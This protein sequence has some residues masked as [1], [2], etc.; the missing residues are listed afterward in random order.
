VIPEPLFVRISVMKA[1][2]RID[3]DALSRRLLGEKPGL[4]AQLKMVPLPPPTTKTYAD[5]GNDCLQAAVLAL[6]Y[7]REKIPH[8]VLIRR[9]STVLHHKDQIGLPGGQV[10]PGES[11]EQAAL[12][13]AGEE[14]GLDPSA[15]RILG[16][17]TPLYVYPSHFCVHPVVGIADTAPLFLPF[18]GE[19]AGIIE[20]PLG[21]L[22]GPESVKRETWNIRG[23]DREVPFYA[24]GEDKIWGATA[25]ILAEFL[26]IVKSA[27]RSS[28][29]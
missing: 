1:P 20:A 22:L 17:L 5:V 9:T 8:L 26:E 10:E 11:F 2:F 12:R 24:V 6:I 21:T 3:P 28:W 25:M 29:R 23:T 7:P 18:P 19:V 4:S 14:I 15:V 16:P 13:E 27:V